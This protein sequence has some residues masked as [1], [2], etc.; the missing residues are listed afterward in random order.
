MST[1]LIVFLVTCAGVFALALLG[2]RQGPRARAAAQ[3]WAT[4][5][6]WQYTRKDQDLTKRWHSPPI[7]GGDSPATSYSARPSRTLR[8]HP[9]PEALQNQLRQHVHHSDHGQQSGLDSH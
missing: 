4:E 8:Q 2:V 5:N 1:G 3:R 6:G 9:H 7:N